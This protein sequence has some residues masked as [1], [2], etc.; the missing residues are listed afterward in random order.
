STKYYVLVGNVS[1]KSGRSDGSVDRL[2]RKSFVQAAGSFGG[3][4]LAPV[5]ETPDKA[6]KRLAGKK[7]VKAFYLAPRVPTFEYAGGKLTVKV[8]I[9]VFTY[10]GKALIGSFTRKASVEVSQPDSSSEDELLAYVGEAA[11][12]QFVASFQ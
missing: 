9:A 3:I 2:F 4:A 1:D 11:L 8:E 7:T 10:P 6:K 5:A 12:K